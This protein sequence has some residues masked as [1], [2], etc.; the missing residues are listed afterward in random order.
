V[1]AEEYELQLF[2]FDV[3]P[4]H[5]LVTLY[6][7]NAVLSNNLEFPSVMRFTNFQ[8]AAVFDVIY[9]DCVC[10]Y[11]LSEPRVLDETDGEDQD[12]FL[13][14]RPPRVAS[15]IHPLVVPKPILAC[16]DCP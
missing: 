15:P 4:L 5:V 8:L 6:N 1:F 7:P 9:K 14:G 12:R 13:Q 16:R 2:P 3:Q 10:N 11:F